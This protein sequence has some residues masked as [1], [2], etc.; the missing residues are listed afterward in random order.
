MTDTPTPLEWFRNSVPYIKAHQGRIFVIQFGGQVVADESFKHLI[1]DIALLDA[2]GVKLV[3]VHGAEPQIAA[4]L[5][6]T[7]SDAP[8]PHKPPVTDRDTLEL[9]KEATGRARL[10]IEALLSTGVTNSPMAGARIRV[11]GGNFVT[12][13][14]LGVHEGTDFQYTGEVR[15]IDAEALQKQLDAHTIVLISPLGYSPTGEIFRL[16]S[17]E[18]AAAIAVELGAAK[19]IFIGDS[20]PVGDDGE[21]VR[22]MTTAQAN[23]W[24]GCHAELA[25]K[26][27]RLLKILS[28]AAYACQHGVA[29]THLLDWQEN[30]ALPRELFTRDGAGTMLSATPYDKSRP[31]TIE[32]VAG[33]LELIRP[34]EEE[35]VLVRRPRDKVET[36]IEQF[37]IMERDGSIIGCAALHRFPDTTAVELACLSVHP[38]YRNETR[39]GQ[40]LE[41]A[42]DGARAM[43]A[44]RIY[45]L[46]TR[47][48]Q[49]FEERGFSRV[50]LADLPVERQAL[51]NYKR[52][53]RILA[54]DL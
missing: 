20:G 28:R 7:G 11:S 13:R 31:A 10:D 4:R 36:D 6:T 50:Q 51:Y 48:L 53:S 2:L 29:R 33:I 35:G 32:D 15:R 38:E 45:V 24:I 25:E 17:A 30:G 26:H 23:D 1:H 14:P 43:G 47:A 27:Q 12:A 42:E 19:L 52:N 18:V 16:S 39:G 54:K 5:P 8:S 3:L 41:T 49:W 9:V 22:E 37:L 34:L 46:T 21:L 44:K 40:L